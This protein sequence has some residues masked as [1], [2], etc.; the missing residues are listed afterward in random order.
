MLFGSSEDLE[1][2]QLSTKKSILVL[3]INDPHPTKNVY[4]YSLGLRKILIPYIPKAGI[5]IYPIDQSDENWVQAHYGKDYLANPNL[6]QEIKDTP[7]KYLLKDCAYKFLIPAER[8]LV[9]SMEIVRND[10]KPKDIS[11]FITTKEIRLEENQVLEVVVN[12]D[13]E[14]KIGEKSIVEKQLTSIDTNLCGK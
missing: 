3:K 6:A 14:G 1:S 11:D 8:K 10:L 12:L 2:P 4:K 5:P 13:A 7:K 9:L